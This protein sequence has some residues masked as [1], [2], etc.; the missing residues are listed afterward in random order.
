M[1]PR[2]RARGLRWPLIV[3]GVL[4][5]LGHIC[6]LPLETSSILG[7]AQA[8]ES[9]GHDGSIHAASCEAAVTGPG[10]LVVVPADTADRLV[11][12]PVVAVVGVGHGVRAV[13]VTPSPPLFLLHASFLI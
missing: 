2:Y 8:G 7:H 12:N 9:D 11:S 4:L 3:L 10:V 13:N 6:E 1:R 5:T